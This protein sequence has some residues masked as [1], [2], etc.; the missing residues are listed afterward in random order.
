MT[1][2]NLLEPESLFLSTIK[3]ARKYN[4]MLD[5]KL[6]RVG[7]FVR[8]QVMGLESKD[9][10]YLVTNVK[11]EDLCEVLSSHFEKII[12]TDVGNRMKVINVVADNGIA[13]EFV[14]PRKDIYGGSGGHTDCHA[15]GDPSF[16]VEMDMGRRDYT[17]NA[18][19][20][21][22]E[23]GEYVDPYNGIDDIKNKIIRCVGKAEERFGEDALR[24]LRGMQFAIR[25]GFDIDLDTKF[26]MI[27]MCM[28]GALDTITG[29]R[30]LIELEKAF[31]K[32]IYKGNKEISWLFAMPLTNYLGGQM[33]FEGIKE[34]CG[35]KV[36]SNLVAM[37]INGECSYEKLKLPARTIEIIE[38]CKKIHP[39]YT[40]HE[41]DPFFD[42]MFKKNHLH[43]D[44][45]NSMKSIG[46]DRGH[47][48]LLMPSK[49]AISSE[50]MIQMGISKFKLGVVQKEL[51]RRV[52]EEVIHNCEDEIYEYL[53]GMKV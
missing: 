12:Q 27:R 44:V 28:N 13:Y 20:Y 22:V 45:L 9:L 23:T 3:K 7:G 15:I 11:Y 36:I 37:F 14:I 30:V 26:N 52:Y 38:I 1:D 18:I 47:P 16:S 46:Y 43:E 49:L 39:Y 6:Y 24:I 19:A 51:C 50:E 5:I 34:V 42:T 48:I 8:D 17:M 31:N 4:E 32:S 33:S 2:K 29:E 10:D 41:D 21:D 35:D 40:N 25:F 53:K